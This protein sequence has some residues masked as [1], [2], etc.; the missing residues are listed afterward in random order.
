MIRA[1]KLVHLRASAP[2]ELAVAEAALLVLD[3]PAIPPPN[4][5]PV[6]AVPDD[7]E[8]EEPDEDD[9]LVGMDALP[10]AKFA[11][12]IRVLFG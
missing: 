11:H 8:V 10:R 2:D 12:A 3:P 9:E 6:L 1:P 4:G 7:E 5:E